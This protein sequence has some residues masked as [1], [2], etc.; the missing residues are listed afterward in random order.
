MAAKDVSDRLV[1]ETMRTVFES[2]RG[3]VPTLL[4]T[5]DARAWSQIPLHKVARR[6]LDPWGLDI[7]TNFIETLASVKELFF[8]LLAGGYLVWARWRR[9]R[10][11]ERSRELTTLKKRLDAL[12][13]ETVRIERAQI[14]ADDARELKKYLDEVT[15]IKLKALEELTHEDLRGDRMFLIFLTQCGDLIHKIQAK[16]S[17]ERQPRQSRTEG[18]DKAAAEGSS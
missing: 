16:I 13:D 8:A 6:Y 4:T 10:E 18:A 12:L 2:D 11:R 9:L 3:S 7:L 5:A 17:I 1:Y 15:R 14:E